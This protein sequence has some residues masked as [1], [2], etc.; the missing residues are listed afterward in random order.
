MSPGVVGCAAPG[1]RMTTVSATRV[2]DE[3]RRLPPDH[4][5]EP[6]VTAADALFVMTTPPAPAGTRYVPDQVYGD[7][8]RP[9]TMHLYARADS[10]ERQPGVVFIHGGGFIEGFPEMMIAYAAGLAAHG[11]VTASIDYRLAGEAPWPA[12]LED[13][14]CAVRWMRANADS[15]GL[16]A[17]RL[18]VAGGSAGGHLA[19]MVA[20]T[21]GRFEGY[22]GQPDVSSA[23][24]TA[25][26]WYP[27]LDLR[28]SYGSE[29]INEV[30]ELFFGHP[31]D[32]ERAG[33]AS[34]VTYVDTMLPTLTFTG[35][36][37]PI[38]LVDTV[39]G[40]HA[41][42]DRRGVPNELVE[43]PGVG[44][45]FDFSRARWLECFDR[46]KT[47]LDDQLGGIA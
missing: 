24:S 33:I 46:L 18:A 34:P 5:V 32:D 3:L 26:L 38:V 19:A 16:D 2:L 35:V 37:D 21:P 13:S 45:S 29:K 14:K 7:V 28:P 6:G 20:S 41:A 43:V 12:A 42:L 36:E 10:S 40:Y 47:W 4:V 17:D 25:V 1:D 31:V 15:I 8:G 11:Y 22:G 9:L 44:H 39:R 27:G 30:T 23:V